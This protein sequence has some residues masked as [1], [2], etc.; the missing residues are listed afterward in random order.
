M[1]PMGYLRFKIVYAKLDDPDA[2]YDE[3][4]LLVR[5]RD[6][7]RD[8]RQAEQITLIEPAVLVGATRSRSRKRR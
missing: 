1:D 7:A 6:D 3:L 4:A 8:R 2:L 5:R